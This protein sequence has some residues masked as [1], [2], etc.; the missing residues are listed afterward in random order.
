[1]SQNAELL[2]YLETGATIT[3]AECYARGWGLSINSRAAEL[4][5]RTGVE[6]DCDRVERNGKVVYEYSLKERIPYG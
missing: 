6:I 2:A 4:R 1:M 3:K 5:K